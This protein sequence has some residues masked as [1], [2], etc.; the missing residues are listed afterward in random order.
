VRLEHVLD[1]ERTVGDAASAGGRRGA[2]GRRNADGGSGGHRR[3]TSDC[4]AQLTYSAHI[5]A[6]PR[7]SV[8]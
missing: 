2:R 7:S 1:V 8:R 6:L 5:V 3:R 4:H